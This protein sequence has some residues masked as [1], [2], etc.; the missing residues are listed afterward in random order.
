MR[1]KKDIKPTPQEEALRVWLEKN[2][3][4][5]D[6]TC[7]GFS[8]EPL[9]AGTEPWEHDS[10]EVRVFRPESRVFTTAYHTGIGHRVALKPVPKEVTAYPRT[11]HAVKWRQDWVKPHPPEV[12]GVFDSFIRDGE[13][14]NQS[15]EDWADE[16][17]YDKDSRSAEKIYEACKEIGFKMRKLFTHAEI[18]EMRGIL[19]D[20]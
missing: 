10:W 18:E 20:Y 7:T 9:Q 11:L 3:V 2:H 13:A 19:E 17:G 1:L 6:I 16:F 12:A 15:F 5:V 4:K 8:S 14:C